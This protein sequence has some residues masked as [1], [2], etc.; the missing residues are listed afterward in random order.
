MKK[1]IW[2]A[3][4]L[5]LLLVAC[6]QKENKEQAASTRT[7]T[8]ET[9]EKITIPAK[10]KRIVVLTAQLGNFKKLGVTPVGMT[11]VYPKSSYLDETGVKRVPIENVE[12]IAKLKPDL[13]IAYS[14]NEQIEKYKKIAKTITFTTSKHS[15]KEMHIEI[16]KILGKEALAKKQ[17]R[18][19]DEK[20]KKD[21]EEVKA[22]IGDDKTFSIMDVQPKQ[23]YLFGTDFGRGG[24]VIY[25]GYGFSLPEK[26]EKALPKEGYLGISLEEMNEYTGDYL[27]VPT[28]D[29][30]EPNL[31]ITNSGVWKKNQAVKQGHVLYCSIKEFI[32]ADPISIE[33][34]S[35]ALKKMLLKS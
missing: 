35:A 34:Q 9:G 18:E 15:F 33:K 22:K 26:V 3:S 14:Q 1:M 31:D 21:G 7:Y 5:A 23:V 2:L 32:Y 25:Q 17:I 20:L 4:L 12:A 6:G 13:I 27:L 30:K 29:G 28:K 16:G 24:E 11:D 10:P 19:M 8:T